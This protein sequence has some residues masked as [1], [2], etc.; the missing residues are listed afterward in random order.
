MGSLDWLVDFFHKFPHITFHFQET[1]SQFNPEEFTY[2]Q[3]LG[4]WAAIC[5]ILGLILLFTTLIFWCIRCCCK[6]P[7]EP[8]K[9]L[10][11]IH[12][13]SNGLFTISIFC[14]LWLGLSLF[15]N[16][17]INRGVST[18]ADSLGDLGN[19]VQVAL[20]KLH[21]LNRTLYQNISENG[22][23]NLARALNASEKSFNET[24]EKKIWVLMRNASQEVDRALNQTQ[25]LNKTVFELDSLKSAAQFLQRVETERWIIFAVLLSIMLVVL[26]GGVVGFCRHSKKGAVLFS[27]LG[28]VIFV[29]TWIL[30]AVSLGAAVGA[31][32]FCADPEPFILRR[33]SRND[34]KEMTKF[35]MSCHES[36]KE[37]PDALSKAKDEMTRDLKGMEGALKETGDIVKRVFNSTGPT[38][39]DIAGLLQ[40]VSDDVKRAGD[41]L[42]RVEAALSCSSSFRSDYAN[43]NDG[44]CNTAISGLGLL[45]C[46]LLLLGLFFFLL[47]VFVSKAWHLYTK[48]PLDYV[49]VDDEDPFLPRG[50]RSNIPADFYG[51]HV[52]N[53]RTRFASNND[54]DHGEGSTPLWSRGTTTSTGGAHPPPAYES[55]GMNGR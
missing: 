38:Y 23:V 32:D 35:Y 54:S 30:L 4:F 19:D 40:N 26:F 3:T 45:L 18:T 11:K 52:Y 13:L 20:Q 51:T 44:L 25:A 22:L 28:I 34:S 36:K 10:K 12:D 29:L 17:R 39:N 41:G 21:R 31:G 14:F 2:L 27:G 43:A 1:D 24:E 55:V 48:R 50:D 46:G 6:R 16:E 15:S 33:F 5:L 49:E 37:L 7:K 47:L 53:P 42:V 8:A 9:R